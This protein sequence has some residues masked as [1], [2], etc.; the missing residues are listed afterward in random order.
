MAQLIFPAPEPNRPDQRYVIQKRMVTAGGDPSHDL[1]LPGADGLLFT[2]VRQAKTKQ[3]SGTAFELH[4]AARARLRVNGLAVTRATVLGS[5][6]RIDWNG[7]SAIFLDSDLPVDAGSSGDA[8]RSLAV[9][10]N[11]A[12]TLQSTGSVQAALDRTLDSLVSM[13]GA[14]TGYLLAELGSGWE[15]TASR[16]ADDAAAPDRKR[17]FSNTIL[18]E[19]LARREP[20]YIENIVGHPWCEAASVIEARIFSAACFPLRVGDRIFG[21][22]FLLTRSPGRSIR[23]GSLGELALLATQAALMLASQAELSSARR[24]NARLRGLVKD[25][26]NALVHSGGKLHELERKLEKLAGTPL[27]VLIL[28]ETGTGKEVVARELHRRSAR[29]DK[30]FVAVNCAAIPGTLLEST[31]FGHE[32]G[33]FTGAVRAQEGKFVAA[34]GGTL[35]LDEIADLPLELQA[36]L[37]RVLQEK[38][39][40]PLGATR[41]VPVDVRILAATHQDLEAAVTS[42]RFRQDLFFR[43]NAACLRI[44]PLRERLDDVETLAAH[45]LEKAGT[46][47][48]LAPDALAALRAHSWPGNVRELEQVITRAA[49]LSEGPEL[50]RE[51]LEIGQARVARAGVASAFPPETTLE[52][53]QGA[54][55][56]EFVSQALERCGGNRAEAARELGVSER[57][58]YRILAQ[59]PTDVAGP[60]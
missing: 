20:V 57:T 10:E 50:R 60:S 12:S 53:A 37:L 15:L 18:Q 33:A 32:R 28:G 41:P 21:A 55:T 11:I 59:S 48:K 31:L 14:E 1:Q 22:V 4:P 27:G 52:Q 49:L 38:V 56:R 43:L 3:V 30:P 47:H 39:V 26:P 7:G 51:D 24:E 13:A 23:Q 44:P 8:S 35:L 16:Q 46:G 6:D 42:G 17:L 5:R 9:L 34:S 19:A 40:D 25:W 58:L 54:F 45:F 29:A 36:K 2:L